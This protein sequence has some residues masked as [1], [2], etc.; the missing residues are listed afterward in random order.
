MVGLCRL[1]TTAA[2][3]CAA[4]AL[5]VPITELEDR[6]IQG[7]LPPTHDDFYTVPDAATLAQVQNGDILRWRKTPLPISAL[8][9]KPLNLQ[10]QYQVLY[11][12]TDTFGNDTATVLSIMVPHNADMGKIL[13]Y[14]MAEDAPTIDCAPSYALQFGAKSK[15]FGI[16]VNQA[17]LGTIDTAF[18]QGWVV[19]MP[20]HQGPKSAWL[21]RANAAH[22]ILD[23][24]RA[25]DR[26]GEFSGIRRGGDDNRNTKYALWGYSGGGI[27]TTGALELR[28][29]YA[30]ELTNIVGAAVGGLVPDLP[31]GIQSLNK[32]AFAGLLLNAMH[33]LGQE[34]PAFA[35][36]AAPRI[37]PEFRA[38][39]DRAAS[40][41]QVPTIA[42]WVGQ[43]ALAIFEDPDAFLAEPLSQDIFA[44]NSL[45]G[46]AVPDVP[47]FVYKGVLDQLSHVEDTDDL[48][49]YYCS[50]GAP[51]LAYYRDQTGTHVTMP[52]AGTG[53][54]MDFLHSVMNGEEQVRGCTRQTVPSGF[55]DIRGSKYIPGF[56]INAFLDILGKPTGPLV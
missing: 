15:F 10:G 47:L 50:N 21:A 13:S 5:S 36:L 7:P 28:A 20:D 44:A 51:S 1:I 26:S 18:Q 33:G 42:E 40:Q 4:A 3:A 31:K 43:D 48:V 46:R 29:E 32:G 35:A 45:G 16:L 25:A 17:E 34:Y 23:G 56:L 11:K 37:K 2:A 39:F 24:L 27:A 14:Q 41:C 38:R 8:G 9:I 55:F 53:R 30:P 49:D 52:L 6:T 19:I 22:A 54:A 12:T